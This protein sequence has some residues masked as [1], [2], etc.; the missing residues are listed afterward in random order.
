MNFSRGIELAKVPMFR[1][2]LLLLGL[3]V[4]DLGRAELTALLRSPFFGWLDTD[5]NNKAWLLHI[6]S[7]QNGPDLNCGM[8]WKP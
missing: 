4:R 8:S 7:T 2:A 3:I 5:R 1:D 6:F